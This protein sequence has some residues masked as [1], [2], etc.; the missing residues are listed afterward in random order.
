MKIQKILVSAIAL[1]FSAYAA[2]ESSVSIYGGI[3]LGV[4]ASKIQGKT[5]TVQEISGFDYASRFGFR[6]VE[7]LGNGLKVGFQ[8]EQGFS[9]DT[10]AELGN[11]KG[12]AFARESNLFIDGKFG[13]FT[14][15]RVGSLGFF[16]STG[17]LK[18]NIFGTSPDNDSAFNMGAG[19]TFG[20]LDNAIVYRTPSLNGLTIHAMY[21][22]KVDG[23][24]DDDSVEKWSKNNH[25]YGLGAKYTSGP[26]DGSIIF[27]A[28][29][30]KGEANP[31]AIYHITAGGS[32][33][34]KTVKPYAIYQFSTQDNAERHHAAALGSAVPLVGG[35]LKAQVRFI[36]LEQTGTKKA[37]SNKAHKPTSDHCWTFG[38]GYNYPFTKRTYLWSYAGYS[39][40]DKNMLKADK[41]LVF[42]GWQAGLG[43]VHRF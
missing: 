43:L 4:M 30:N 37:A 9:A 28:K 33:D 14:F 2:A 20:R 10:G 34:F 1:T 17:I 7:D 15:G 27:E 39:D 40:S 38:L 16:Q 32:Y 5:T 29:D 42:D 36:Y 8:L 6:G 24:P 23:V 21:S 13:R 18:G 11:F 22:N 12:R 25:Y 35:T 3:D 31:K 26:A 19:L 41:K